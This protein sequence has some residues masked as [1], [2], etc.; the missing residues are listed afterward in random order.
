MPKKSA[1]I[2]L[3]RIHQNKPE[4]F[5]VHPG[6]PFWKN[7]DL[8]TWSIPKGEIDETEDAYHAAL[9]EFHEETGIQITPEKT[10]PLTPVK[11]KGGKIIYA[12]GVKGDFDPAKLKS[13]TFEMEWPPRSGKKAVFPEVDKGEWFDLHEAKEKINPAQYFLLEELANKLKKEKE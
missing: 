13:N 2:L 12:W 6:G 7:K 8:H 5:L 9:R 3:Y 10:I 4:F 11:Q 1:G